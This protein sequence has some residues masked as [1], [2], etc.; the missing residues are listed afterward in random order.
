MF[1]NNLL[2][3]VDEEK[4]KNNNSEMKVSENS[5]EGAATG[6]VQPI[7]GR[8]TILQQF[9]ILENEESDR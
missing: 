4:K 6:L 1:S 9:P 8:N 7:K 2:L 3:K 5:Y